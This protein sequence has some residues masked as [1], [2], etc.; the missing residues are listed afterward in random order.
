MYECITLQLRTIWCNRVDRGQDWLDRFIKSC[1][2]V[3][4]NVYNHQQCFILQRLIIDVVII[5][6]AS[7]R[8]RAL[9]KESWRKYRKIIVRASSDRNFISVCVY[10]CICDTTRRKTRCW[11][12]WPRF[13]QT[14]IRSLSD[15]FYA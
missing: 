10:A 11:V 2:R 3:N 5:T 12:G 4:E 1:K 7:T 13:L 6:I 9:H 15:S 8:W 14:N